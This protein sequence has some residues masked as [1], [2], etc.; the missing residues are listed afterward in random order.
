MQI[1]FFIHD[2]TQLNR[3]GNDIGTQY[4]SGVYYHDD[5]QKSIAEKLVAEL[6][7]SGKYNS[8]IVTEIQ[9]LQNFYPAEDYHQQYFKNNPNQGYCAAVVRP[10]Y[11]K[12]IK[13]YKEFLK[14]W[15][16]KKIGQIYKSKL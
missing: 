5:E 8:K 13:T 1:F 3:Q 4:R 16:N 11:E 2:P 6:E 7:S 14:N 9:K 10:K 15:N 12:F